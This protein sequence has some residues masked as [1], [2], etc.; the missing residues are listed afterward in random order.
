MT[1]I[2]ITVPPELVK[3]AESVGATPQQVIDGFIADLC[4]LPGT[5]GSD[6]RRLAA[7]WFDRVVWPGTWDSDTWPE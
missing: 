7:Q 2:T 5:N 6:E 4:E 3:L 1:T